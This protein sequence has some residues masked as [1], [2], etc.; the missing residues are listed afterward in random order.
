[1]SGMKRFKN[2]AVLMG[3]PSAER[4]VSLCSGNAVAG[5]LAEAG[6]SVSTVEVTG[7]EFSLP[8]ATEAVFIALHGTYGEDGEV[9]RMLEE[10]GVPYT[11]SGPAASEA[12][13]DKKLSKELFI[14]RGIP[15]PA[16]EILERNGTRKLSFPLVVKPPRQGSSIG[17]HIVEDESEW[18]TSFEDAL[19]Y[20][21]EVLVETF[22]PGRELTVGVVDR[23]TLPAVEI[24]PDGEWYDYEAKYES[25]GTTNY[26]VPAPV[27]DDIAEECSRIALA[28]FDALGCRGFGRVD[29]RLDGSNEPS[30]LEM[31]TIPGFTESSL[32]PKAAGAAGMNFSE[33]CGRIMELARLD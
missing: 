12:G 8:A 9:Q 10:K 4:E 15:T 7:H 17:I 27:S 25:G 21:D 19:K 1:M 22:V 31:N 2:I 3:G 11:G 33:L 18:D 5:G 24:V 28:T 29:F 23:Q 6:Y 13:F 30:V 16:Y 14:A 32:L 26:L 20:G